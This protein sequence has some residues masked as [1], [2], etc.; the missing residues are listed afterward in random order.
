MIFAGYFLSIAYLCAAARRKRQKTDLFMPRPAFFLVLLLAAL[1]ALQSPAQAQSR[2]DEVR[3]FLEQRDREIKNVLG[4]RE[5]FTDEQREQLKRVINNGIDFT[6]MGRAALG[7]FWADTAPDEQ[8]EFVDVFSQIVRNQSL[9]DLDAYRSVV[10]YENIAAGDETAHVTTTTVYK[11][12]P[13]KVEYVLGRTNEQWQVQDIILD[14]V[15]TADGYARSFQ[16]V[17][18]KRG[19]DSLMNSLR[20]KLDGMRS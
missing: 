15:S 20:K 5:T 10:T 16:A 7:P 4:D 2:S 17:V 3:R 11:D 13:M 9:S 18:R 6:A 12:I 1:F 8:Q 14:D 19:F